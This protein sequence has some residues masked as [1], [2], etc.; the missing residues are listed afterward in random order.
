MAG[1]VHEYLINICK[2]I[3]KWTTMVYIKHCEIDRNCLVKVF[4]SVMM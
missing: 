4:F 1:V 3:L 2:C